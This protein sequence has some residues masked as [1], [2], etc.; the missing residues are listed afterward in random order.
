VPYVLEL[1]YTHIELLPI[2][3]HPFGGSWAYQTTAPFAPSARWGTPDDLRRFV[4]RCHASGIGVLFDWVAA[5]FP[6]D[7]HA[8]A[9]FDGTCLY[10]HEDPRRGRHPDWGTRIYNYGRREVSNFL[11]ANALYW[12]REFHADG[13]RVDAVASMLYHDYSRAPGEWLPNAWGGRERRRNRLPAPLQRRPRRAGLQL[14][15]HRVSAL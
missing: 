5:H 1:G 14:Q 3:E 2:A 13:L 6:A 15:D 7:A 11:I 12:L 10:E 8:L 9:R 4:D